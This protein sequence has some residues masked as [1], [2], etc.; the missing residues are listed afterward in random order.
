MNFIPAKSKYL[1]AC[2]GI[3]CR[4]PAESP[5]DMQRILQL[6]LKKI[7][8]IEEELKLVEKEVRN[9]VSF[10]RDGHA[11]NAVAEALEKAEAREQL[12][13]AQINNLKGQGAQRGINHT[14]GHPERLGQP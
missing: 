13:K 8:G 10:I 6:S 11:S 7:R 3:G 12:L 2:S 4:H 1:P 9:C 14:S 5:A